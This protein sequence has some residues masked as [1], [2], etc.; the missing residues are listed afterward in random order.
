MSTAVAD[1]QT[2]EDHLVLAAQ[3]ASTGRLARTLA[4][5][6]HSYAASNRDLARLHSDRGNLFL[7]ELRMAGAQVREQAALMV[8][9]MA[10]DEAAE[11]MMRR[12]VRHAV[13]TPPLIN[14]DAAGVSYTMARTWQACARAI[15]P[16]LDEVQEI[17]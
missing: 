7:A 1:P 17:W 6:W 9:K 15:D 10:P 16:L 12:A 5:Q 4:T 3:S 11:E 13:R 14:Y 2:D 8:V